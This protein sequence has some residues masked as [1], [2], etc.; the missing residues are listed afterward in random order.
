VLTVNRPG[1]A[2]LAE[3]DGTADTAAIEVA[4]GEEKLIG[5]PLNA[6]CRGA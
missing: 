1:F 2:L 3:G 6:A 5:L 4:G